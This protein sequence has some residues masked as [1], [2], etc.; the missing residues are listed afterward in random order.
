[1]ISQHEFDWTITEGEA[2]AICG[3]SESMNPY[4]ETDGP[5]Y[6]IWLAGYRDQAKKLTH[7]K[8]GR[9]CLKVES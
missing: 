7:D 8:K 2:A 5:Q 1:M 3:L 9:V 4:S 6:H